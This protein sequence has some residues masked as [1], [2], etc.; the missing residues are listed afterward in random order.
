MD[1]PLNEIFI[2]REKETYWGISNPLDRST[3]LEN[4]SED[5]DIK[6]T[7]SQNEFK[8][9][10]TLCDNQE[11]CE[12]LSTIV[13]K[14]NEDSASEEISMVLRTSITSGISRSNKSKQINMAGRVLVSDINVANCKRN[15]TISI[16]IERVSCVFK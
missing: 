9:A 12:D 6:R 4:L 7:A 10:P 14:L 16:R 1:T 5:V 3:E 8:K 13:S 2:E 15:N 11:D